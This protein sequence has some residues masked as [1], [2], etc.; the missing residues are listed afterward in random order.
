MSAPRSLLI[1]SALAEARTLSDPAGNVKLAKG[2]QG[3]RRQAARDDA[4]AAMILAVARGWARGVFQTQ[5][6]HTL[7]CCV[8]EPG[9]VAAGGFRISPPPVA[10]AVVRCVPLGTDWPV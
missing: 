10:L 4:A 9:R 3:G 1:R 6:G 8:Y 7:P 2:S 5:H